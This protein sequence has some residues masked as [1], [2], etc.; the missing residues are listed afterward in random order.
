MER[1]DAVWAG[2]CT[3]YQKLA[4]LQLEGSILCARQYDA[5]Q[6]LQVQ[7]TVYVLLRGYKATRAQYPQPHSRLSPGMQCNLQ[8]I[9]QAGS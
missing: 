7:D 2:L 5:W 1:R 9:M 3:V 4:Q 8:A 6:D